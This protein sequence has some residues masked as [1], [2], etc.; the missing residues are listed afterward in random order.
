MGTCDGQSRGRITEINGPLVKGTGL[1]SAFLGEQ[2]SVGKIALP[3]EVI[4]ASRETAVI[5]VYEDTAG[6]CAGEEIILSGHPLSV[7]LAPGLVG[8]IF[9]GL[10]RSL[11][12]MAQSSPF[13]EKK[14]NKYSP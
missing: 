12:A 1:A 13:I 14:T 7:E 11:R 10:Q 3:G 6:L 5:Q 9:D 2:V 8:S 4:R